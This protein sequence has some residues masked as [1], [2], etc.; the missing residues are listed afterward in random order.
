[1]TGARDIIAGLARASKGYDEIL[2]TLDSAFGDKT[3]QKLA[4]RDH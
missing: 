4:L 3:L 2:K 1:M